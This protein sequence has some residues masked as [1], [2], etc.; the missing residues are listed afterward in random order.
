MFEYLDR[1]LDKLLKKALDSIGAVLIIGPKWCGKTTTA[2]QQSNSLI[3]LQDPRFS[4]SYLKLADVDPLSLLDGEKPRLIDE[5]QMAPQLW[6]A[7][8]FSVDELEGEGLY[9]LTGSTT[10]DD[11]I[12][13]HSGAGRIHRLK[14]LPMSLYE[15]KD[16]NGKISLMELF[17]NPN[18]N[19][20]GIS[21]DLSIKDLIFVACRGGWPATLNKKTKE[22]QLFIA[23]S[24]FDTICES[25]MSTVDGVKRNP[26]RVRI[27]L[28]SYARNISTLA[29]NKTII[30]DIKEQQGII[31]ETTYYSYINALKKLFVIDEIDA[32]SPNIRS[33]KTIKKTP[34]KSFTDPSIAVAAL[35]LTPEKLLYDLETFGFIFENLCSRDLSIYSMDYEGKVLY[36]HDQNDLK[37]DCILTLNNGDYALIEFKLGSSDEEK[38]AKNLLRLD[39]LIKEKR[40]EGKIKIPQAKFLAII[41]G[42]KF[43]YTRDDGVKVI[44]IGC[45]C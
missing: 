3:Q 40:N 9:I 17:K 8:R 38:A 42:G 18:L 4:K 7:V 44:P 35:D 14:M 10:V 25:D 37:V 32:W 19:I 28:K 45:L 5:W 15:S 43:A 6:D 34:K 31:S 29:S 30:N 23:K 11:S 27:L 13:M 36:Y 16:S 41:S 1:Y 12:I 20:N 22:Q 24:Y 21:S 26:D 2:K 33:S 39:K